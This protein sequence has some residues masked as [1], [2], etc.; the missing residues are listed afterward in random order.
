MGKTALRSRIRLRYVKEYPLLYTWLNTSSHYTY[1]ANVNQA[2]ASHREKGCAQ[3][4]VQA[5]GRGKWAV[6]YTVHSM[7]ALRP[8]R[9]SDPLQLKLST[10]LRSPCPG[11]MPWSWSS[12]G[13]TPLCCSAMLPFLSPGPHPHCSSTAGHSDKWPL[14]QR[15]SLQEPWHKSGAHCTALWLTDCRMLLASPASP[16]LCHSP[17]H[18]CS[19]T[20][21]PRHVPETLH[22]AVSALSSM[23]A[24]GQ[25]HSP[26]QEHLKLPTGQ[27]TR[28]LS[29]PLDLLGLNRAH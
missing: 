28:I 6:K 7:Q 2:A 8:L 20:V 14:L 16:L 12:G 13:S 5:V 26:E 19:S 23:A 27:P 17:W 11:R 25:V 3:N 15:S 18:G 9:H 22:W 10:W 21:P 1:I 29:V 4:T 24:G